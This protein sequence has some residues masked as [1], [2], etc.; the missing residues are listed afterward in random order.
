MY[1]YLIKNEKNEFF[2]PFDLIPIH[3]N[4]YITRDVA[5][6]APTS[7]WVFCSRNT[8]LGT[9]MIHI[10]STKQ[11]CVD[12]T[13]SKFPLIFSKIHEQRISEIPLFVH[14]GTYILGVFLIHLDKFSSPP[15]MK[16]AECLDGPNYH[17][18]TCF[19]PTRESCGIV[20][21]KWYFTSMVNYSLANDY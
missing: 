7:I 8:I 14:V 13:K 11:K 18:S 10:G 15:E 19:S 2:P 4:Q 17:Q 6:F 12:E 21:Q 5:D 16:L 9:Q 20:A 1:H 3:M